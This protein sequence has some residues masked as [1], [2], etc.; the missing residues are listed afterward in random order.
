[1][2]TIE[3]VTRP[4]RDHG[5]NLAQY[6]YNNAKTFEKMLGNP[7]E[8]DIEDFAEELRQLCWDADENFRQYSPFEFFA[9]ELNTATDSEEL[10]EAYDTS[11]CEGVT[12]FIN[13]LTES[14]K[15]KA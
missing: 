1:M 14:L 7:D 9:H 6:N 5:Q 8:D 10:W 13:Q 2:H 4:G 11:I 3:S 12:S 15:S